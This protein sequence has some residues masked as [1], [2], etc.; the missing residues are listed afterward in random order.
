MWFTFANLDNIDEIKK[1]RFEFAQKIA[2][3]AKEQ[4]YSV[5]DSFSIEELKERA[6]QLYSAYRRILEL[7]SN[8]GMYD[9]R[10]YSVGR[11]L[12][13][14]YQDMTDVITIREGRTPYHPDNIESIVAVVKEA[15]EH[16][17]IAYSADYLIEN[18]NR[19]LNERYKIKLTKEEIELLENLKKTITNN[20]FD[21]SNVSDPELWEAISDK[22]IQKVIDVS[23]RFDEDDNEWPIIVFQIDKDNGIFIGVEVGDLDSKVSHKAI[24]IQK[25]EL[26]KF[27]K[28]II[29]HFPS[30][31]NKK[32]TEIDDAGDIH[33]IIRQASGLDNRVKL[34]RMMAFE[35]YKKWKNGDEIPPGKYFATNRLNAVGTDFG[36]EGDREVFIFSSNQNNFRGDFGGNLVSIVPMHLDGNRL[37]GDGQDLNTTELSELISMLPSS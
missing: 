29:Y 35:E 25:E 12:F 1:K 36:N 22:K 13:E 3:E 19:L 33:R 14:L 37:I 7:S 2:K 30:D 23:K 15:I 8:I 20:I 11:E 28:D 27:L 32:I 10:I 9:S 31:W 26:V 4:Y 5:D 18:I 6:E 16:N 21:L 24:E 34:Y 17:E